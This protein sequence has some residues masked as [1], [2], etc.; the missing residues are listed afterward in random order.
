MQA[1]VR[2]VR[3]DDQEA[4]RRAHA[5][6]RQAAY[7][8]RL[9]PAD[10]LLPADRR[11]GDADR[12]DGDGI[13]RDPGRLRRCVAP[14]P[15]ALTESRSTRAVRTLVR[16]EVDRPQGAVDSTGSAPT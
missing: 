14:R 10:D 4:D 1:R 9:S 16:L 3:G 13:D 11:R 2:G 6:H 7:R 15:R 5:R 8:L 12:T